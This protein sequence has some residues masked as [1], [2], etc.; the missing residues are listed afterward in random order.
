MGVIR[1]KIFRVDV[2]LGGNCPG[3]TIL[4]G[5]F[6]WWKLAGGNQPVGNFACV[7][8]HVTHFLSQNIHW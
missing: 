1:V 7:S 6:L 2:F 8:F 4:G 5:N 3:G